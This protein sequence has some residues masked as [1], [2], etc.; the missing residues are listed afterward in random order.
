[1]NSS[2]PSVVQLTL[3]PASVRG[4]LVPTAGFPPAIQDNLKQHM[5]R[6]FLD[7]LG[8]EQDSVIQFRVLESEP[9]N[10]ILHISK[11]VKEN[12]FHKI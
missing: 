1:M 5:K 10:R 9:D 7:N 4:G 12:P 6:I 3:V 11:V 2:H 8:G